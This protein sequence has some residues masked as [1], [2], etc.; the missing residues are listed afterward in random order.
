[1]PYL[2][3]SGLGDL[4]LWEIHQQLR[5]KHP[6]DRI[7]WPAGLVQ[8]SPRLQLSDARNVLKVRARNAGCGADRFRN[9]YLIRLV[10]GE[11]A[12]SVRNQA[13]E[14]WGNFAG[15]VS[16]AD[17]PSWFYTVRTTIVQF[18]P[19]PVKSFGAIPAHQDVRPVGCGGAGR[20]AIGR[21][22]LAVK[23]EALRV[24][25]E[26]VQL[27][28]GTSAGIQ[29]HGFIVHIHMQLYPTH[30]CSRLHQSRLPQRVQCDRARKNSRGFRSRHRA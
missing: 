4:Q 19:A 3:G 26:P 17:F 25:C 18:A 12:G 7:E 21:M 29:A 15:H 23:R 27:G 30:V 2:E 20:R 5:R 28:Q 10:R 11:M 24:Q 6:Q 14:A 13:L 8:R 1:M 16:N 9:E 22:V